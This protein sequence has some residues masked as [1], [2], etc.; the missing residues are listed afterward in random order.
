MVDC[1]DN[2]FFFSGC[3]WK[4]SQDSNTK[5]LLR[6]P[7]LVMDFVPW[8][9]R[10]TVPVIPR[11]GRSDRSSPRQTIYCCIRQRQSGKKA[12]P[13]TAGGFL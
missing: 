4:S 3:Q 2:P 1:P 12:T 9:Q 10:G 13:D 6:M 5:A 11:A 7:G 8:P